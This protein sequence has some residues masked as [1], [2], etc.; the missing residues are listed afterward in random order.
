MFNRYIIYPTLSLALFII[1]DFFDIE[2]DINI[3]LLFYLIV[4]YYYRS[5]IY[6]LFI[7]KYTR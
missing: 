7:D 2:V 3:L 6:I 4:Y 1:S 5:E